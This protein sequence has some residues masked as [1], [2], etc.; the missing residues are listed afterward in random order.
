M[1]E[2]N[3]EHGLLL[4]RRKVYIPKDMNLRLELLKLHHDTL[5]AGHPGRWKT[6]ELISRN[7]WWPGMSIDVKKYVMGCDTCQRNKN[8]KHVPYGLLQPLEV[9]SSPWERITIDLITQLPDSTDEHGNICTAIIVVVDRLTKQAHFYAHNDHCTAI[10]IADTFLNQVF[11]HHGLPRQ[12]ISDRGPQFASEVFE[13]FCRKLGIKPSK[14]TAYH[15]ETDGQTERVNQILEQYLRIFCSYRQDDW[16][17]LLPVAEFAYNNTP[18]ESTKLSPFFI[19]YGRNPQMAPDVH[20]QLQHPSLEELFL[21]R[22]DAQNEAKASLSLAAERMKWY[23]DEHKQDVKFKVG[24]KVLI[25]GADLRV[26]T[27]SAKL[28]AKNYGPY[29]ITKQLG[30][31]TFKLKLPYQLRVHPIFH[32]SKFIPFNS[33]TIGTRQ[34]K[35]R[36]PEMVDGNIE[37]EVDQVL[38][39]RIHR[40]RVQYLIK[41]KNEDDSENSWEPLRHVKHCWKMIRKFHHDHPDAPEP[42][43]IE[44]S[45]PLD[46]E[47]NRNIWRLGHYE[48]NWSHGAR[49]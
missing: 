10:D 24:D 39:A 23:F 3:F 37:F 15:P 40:G 19:E 41:W 17:R 13:E 14:S 46:S 36:I 42:K 25:K 44:D 28:A 22:E 31:V 4:H 1:K 8:S 29:E 18:S 7:Y 33:D 32:A 9:P 34:P 48:A 30:P 26:Q 6:L 38:D 35:G 45:R 43:S 47:F 49:L 20:G 5:L 2:W 27:K 16:A 12:I 21:Y 11:R